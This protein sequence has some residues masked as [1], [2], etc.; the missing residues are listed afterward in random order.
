MNKDL[1]IDNILEISQASYNKIESETYPTKHKS[2]TRTLNEALEKFGFKNLYEFTHFLKDN[3]NN[4]IYPDNI[5]TQAKN[6]CI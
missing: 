1:T 6:V 3:Y 2:P 4:N 5:F